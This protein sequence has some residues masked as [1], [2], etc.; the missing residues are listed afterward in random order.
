MPQ[1]T[2]GASVTMVTRKAAGPERSAKVGAAVPDH[3]VPNRRRAEAWTGNH[4]FE[5]PK[6]SLEQRT[7]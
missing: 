1:L 4:E 6:Y 5:G 3:A 7:V 2:Y